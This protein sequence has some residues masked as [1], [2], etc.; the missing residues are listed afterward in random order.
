MDKLQ[1][2][3]DKYNKHG[4][5]ALHYAEKDAHMSPEGPQMVGMLIVAGAS[6]L[7]MRPC[8]VDGCDDKCRQ[9]S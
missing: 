9:P 1:R 7:P 3:L 5:T 2:M 6:T 8:K 4:M